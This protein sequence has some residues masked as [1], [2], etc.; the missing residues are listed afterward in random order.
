M[1]NKH[2]D[3]LR[4]TM[5]TLPDMAPEFKT[6][7]YKGCS[8]MSVKLIDYPHN[9]YKAMYTLATSCWGKKI[10]K[11]EDTSIEGRIMVI[12]AVL[13]RVALPLAY[14]AAQF[15]FACERIPRWA[16]DQI[17]R[18]RLGVVF[19]SQGT[20]DNNHLDAGFFEHDEIWNDPELKEAFE[21]AAKQCKE[22]YKKIVE[23][24]QGSWQA[25]RSIL[26][27]S[28]THAFSFAAN[29]AAVQSMLSKRLKFCEADATVGFAWLVKA[30]IDKKFPLLGKYLFPACDFANSCSYNKSYYLSNCFG[31]LFKPCGRNK[32]TGNDDYASFN[33]SCSNRESIM[34]QLGIYIPTSEET[35]EYLK[36]DILDP[37]D[38]V[39][40]NEK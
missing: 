20:R 22:V 27:I 32:S 28:N 7:F 2:I 16:F 31:C 35:R 10:D 38:L 17:A 29:F 14:E 4:R 3:D 6:K 23:K 15:T 37:K 40:F 36:E 12:K 25:A 13:Q 18:A 24:G 39:Y 9:P 34:E 11:W 5:G 21:N 8:G 30:E 33:Q 26:P 19:S 1:D